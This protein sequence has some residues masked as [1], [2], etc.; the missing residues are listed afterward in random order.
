[1]LAFGTAGLVTY[2]VLEDQRRV[3]LLR[4]VWA[5]TVGDPRRARLQRGAHSGWWHVAGVI[6]W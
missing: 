6:A 1:M 2:L 5:R 4:L 3:D